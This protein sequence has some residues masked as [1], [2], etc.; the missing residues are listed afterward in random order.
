[1]HRSVLVNSFFLTVALK[2]HSEEREW[3]I[4]KAMKWGTI[5][6]RLPV[7]LPL[8]DGTRAVT[9]IRGPGS[10]T[11]VWLCFGSPCFNKH[12]HAERPCF[13]KSSPFLH[14][15]SVHIAAWAAQ[16]MCLSCLRVAVSVRSALLPKRLAGASLL[17]RPALVGWHVG[18][19]T[20]L[21]PWHRNPLKAV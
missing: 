10:L 5:H 4:D 16:H 17:R 7:E 1:M 15:C 20:D 11:C 18:P 21:L 12:L 6:L 19:A 8:V 14:K 9:E 3:Q 2:G 13:P